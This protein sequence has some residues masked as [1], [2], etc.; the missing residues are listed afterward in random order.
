MTKQEAYLLVY[1]DLMQNPMFRGCYDARNGNEDYMYG[2]ST[3]ME[4]IAWRAGGDEL[5]DEYNTH[6]NENITSSE[7]I[8]ELF[9]EAEWQ[10]NLRNAKIDEESDKF[11]KEFD[12]YEK[13]HFDN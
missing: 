3:V 1:K 6:W 2:I 12:G 5:I 4:S 7:A 8:A 9:R 13:A 10:K 11:E